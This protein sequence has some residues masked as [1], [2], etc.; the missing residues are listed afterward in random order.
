M[1]SEPEIRD[2][3]E[4]QDEQSVQ[5]LSYSALQEALH[6]A[7]IGVLATR[8]QDQ[9]IREMLAAELFQ[10]IDPVVR[11]HLLGQRLGRLLPTLDSDS[12]HSRPGSIDEAMAALKAKLQTVFAERQPGVQESR[13]TMRE[14]AQNAMSLAP[15]V[16]DSLT[17]FVHDAPMFDRAQ[18]AT[19][20]VLTRYMHPFLA[21]HV[22]SFAA[23]A[24]RSAA[25][26]APE[27]EDSM[28]G[29]DEKQPAAGE[30]SS[31]SSSHEGA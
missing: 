12:P 1:V 30:L 14:R 25:Q 18:E 13:S 24:V 31:R 9:R 28:T 29:T 2:E 4:A 5:R 6:G 10:A 17:T 16:V 7:I 21:R 19:T 3:G 22:V 20:V 23:A 11:E 26:E 8:F 27:G 15:S